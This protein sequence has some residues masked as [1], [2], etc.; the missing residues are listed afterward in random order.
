MEMGKPEQSDLAQAYLEACRLDVEAFKPGNVSIYSQGHGMTVEDFLVS[1]QASVEPLTDPSLSLGERIYYAVEATKDRVGCNTNLGIVLLT[2][3]LM[4]AVQCLGEGEVRTRLHQILQT[5][6]VQD[7]EW[8]YRAIRL[9]NPGGLGHAEAE[10]VNKK[11]TVT[12]LKAMELAKQWDRIAYNYTSDY[13]DVFQLAIP[14]YH[15]GVYQWADERWAAVYVFVR[16]L[17]EIPDSHVERKFGKRYA[18]MIS[19]K[20]AHLEDLLQRAVNPERVLPQLKEADAAFKAAGI[21]PGTT[22]DLTVATVLAVRLE[23][24]LTPGNSRD[25]PGQGRVAGDV[26]P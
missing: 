21:N 12:L 9:A 20:C 18:S 4:A 15:I 11:P 23:Q 14:G 25:G 24:L 10:D 26:V 22:A 13:K 7:A 19:A 16:L 1:A 3:P 8:V 6:T 5:T 2:A 17:R